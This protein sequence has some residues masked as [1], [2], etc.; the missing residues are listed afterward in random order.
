MQES[1]L[2]GSPP[3][4]PNDALIQ[5][6]LRAS[7]GSIFNPNPLH[8]YGPPRPSPD[9]AGE[10]DAYKVRITEFFCVVLIISTTLGRFWARSRQESWIFGLDDLMVIP[11]CLCGIGYMGSIIAYTYSCYG[12]HMWFCTYEQIEMIYTVRLSDPLFL[13]CCS[14]AEEKVAI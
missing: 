9:L 11:A 2:L 7:V 6:G 4:T 13:Y 14:V 12:Q 5:I 8:P 10:S 3:A 1:A